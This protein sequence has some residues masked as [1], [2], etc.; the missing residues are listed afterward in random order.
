MV[1]TPGRATLLAF[2]GIVLLGGVNGTAIRVGNAELDPFWNATLRFGVASIVLFVVA[3]AWRLTLPR[4]RALL[5]SVI[6]GVLSFGV[7]FAL[8]NWALVSTPA[9]LA[10]VILALVPL[11]TLLLASAQG[12]ERF[13]PQGAVGSLIS[14]GGVALVFGERL[15]GAVPLLSMLA[16]LLG[17]VSIAEANV[18][19]KRLPACH[20]VVNNAIGMGVGALLLLVLTFV[21]GQRMTLPVRLETVVAV[22]YL[23][24]VGSV[25][26]F[27]LYLIVIRRWSAS[28]TSYALLLMPLVSI[29]AAAIVLN[30]PV[31]PLL[32]IGGVLVLA[33]VYVGAF[34]PSMA[35]PLPGLF[36]RPTLAPAVTHRTGGPPEMS[37]PS[38]P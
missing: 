25:V 34:A 32:L 18:V 2:V 7:T 27:T 24:L 20:P 8:I 21:T 36:R 1:G 10:Q 19:A 33:G 11:L 12:A 38:C 15:G 14:L 4:G 26:V 23:A 29:L 6:Y 31:T 17:A 5:G 28:A 16:V 35:V 22:A 13:R 3:G 30:E 37:T 9:G